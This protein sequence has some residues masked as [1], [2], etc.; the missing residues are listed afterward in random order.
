MLIVAMIPSGKEIDTIQPTST[1]VAAICSIPITVSYDLLDSNLCRR[2][3]R[4]DEAIGSKA[5]GLEQ[6]VVPT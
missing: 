6:R 2:E 5:H 4:S 1:F 3:E